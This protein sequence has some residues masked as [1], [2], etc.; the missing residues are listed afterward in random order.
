MRDSDYYA[1]GSY[2]DPNAPWN[3]SDPDPIEVNVEVTT[4]VKNNLIVTTTEY[5]RTE[6]GIELLCTYKDVE[7]AVTEQCHLV[8]ELMQ[9]LANY[10]KAELDSGATGKRK[11]HLQEVLACCEGWEQ[12]DIEVEEFEIN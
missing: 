10:V 8:P 5:E 4:L 11:W 3:E 12:T 7:E 2:N 9:M 1:P 6:D